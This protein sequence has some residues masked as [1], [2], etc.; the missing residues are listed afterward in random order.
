MTY[1]LGNVPQNSMNF[2]TVSMDLRC[3][4][5]MFKSLDGN[6][7]TERPYDYGIQF[8]A[9]CGLAY[10][11]LEYGVKATLLNR[12]L[13]QMGI[14]LLEYKHRELMFYAMSK[15]GPFREHMQLMDDLKNTGGLGDVSNWGAGS[16]VYI[17]L[18]LVAVGNLQREELQ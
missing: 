14:P 3:V 11:F 18:N 6:V 9:E 1:P 10:D 4:L 7:P 16:A 5:A 8:K 17:F 2:R 15:R 13:V 12:M